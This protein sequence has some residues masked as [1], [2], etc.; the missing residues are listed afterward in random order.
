MNA[1]ALARAYGV[2]GRFADLGDW[3]AD[4]LRPSTTRT[5]PAIRI[6]VRVAEALSRRRAR[7]V[8]RC[9]RSGTN[10]TIT[11]KRSARSPSLADRARARIGRRRVRAQAAA[12]VR[13]ERARRRHRRRAELDGRGGRRRA[14]ARPRARRRRPGRRDRR[15]ARRR[16]GCATR[17]AAR[18]T[19]R[20]RAA[21]LPHGYAFRRRSL[22][23]SAD[24]TGRVVRRR[25]GAAG[26]SRRPAARRA[27]RARGRA[28]R[29]T[30][31]RRRSPEPARSSTRR[32][33]AGC[34]HAGRLG[35]RLRRRGQRVLDRPRGA[36]D[37][38]ARARRRRRRVRAKRAASLA[39][40]S[41]ATRL[42]DVARAFYVR[43]DRARSR[44]P[45]SRPSRMRER[46]RSPPSRDRG[47]E[48][49]RRRSSRSAMRALGS[50]RRRRVASAAS[51][52]TRASEAGVERGVA[53]RA[54]RRARWSQPRY[55]PAAGALLL[56]YREAGLAGRGDRAMS[57]CSTRLRGGLIVSVQAWPGSALDDPHVIA[58]MARAAQDE[59]RGRAC[60]SQ[61]VANLRARARAGRR[62][63]RR[64][65]QARVR[66]LR[67]VHH[68]DARRGA[69]D[70]RRAGAD[71]VAFDATARPRPGGATS[72]DLVAAIHAAGALAMADCATAE[73]AWRRARAR[74]RHRGDDALRLHA[75]DGKVTRCRRSLW[76]GEIAARR[77]L[78]RLRGRR[79]SRRPSCARR[80]M[81]A[82]TRS[83]WEPRS[84]MSIGSCASL[85]GLPTK[86]RKP[87]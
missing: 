72:R 64:A 86:D 83:S 16:R 41:S 57:A 52:P 78:R 19:P 81:R 79:P 42:R 71:I 29:R 13:R 36:R 58:A 50:R 24:T 74:S 77:C 4:E 5:A 67:A 1:L 30:R 84:P 31:R 80:S 62:A 38:H 49:P 32:D 27:D 20:V 12:S 34:V 51:L 11:A 76:C 82:P 37:A 63:D 15:G 8:R 17:C 40:S 73:D 22:R 39:R 25:A 43:R 59:R 9:S 65:D 2:R 87:H 68:A 26:G 23:A 61:G 53:R 21:S 45:H 69:C 10:S 18:S 54:C 56:A 66:R 3:G 70:R 7:R 35:L 33:A 6:N 60:A 75:G 47:A 28:R 85:Q 44:S 46:R 48:P 55:E 14:R